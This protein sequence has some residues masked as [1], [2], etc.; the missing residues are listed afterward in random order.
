MQNLKEF[1]R[2]EMSY[3]LTAMEKGSLISVPLTY[4]VQFESFL[5]TL[6]YPFKMLPFSTLDESVTFRKCL[7]KKE[8]VC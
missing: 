2:E 6:K 5:N 4:R 1:S 8:S 3:C 7:Q